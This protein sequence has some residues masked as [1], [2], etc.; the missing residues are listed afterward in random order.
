MAFIITGTSSGGRVADSWDGNSANAPKLTIQFSTGG[1]MQTNPNIT[2]ELHH[3]STLFATLNNPTFNSG[4]G[5]LSWSGTLSSN[6]T[7]PAGEEVSLDITTN[8]QNVEFQIEYDSQTKPSKILLP[9]NTVINISG[10][11]FYDAPY[12]EGT[13]ITSAV[14]GETVYV[15]INVED[16]FGSSDITSTD[17]SIVASNGST[18]DTTLTDSNVTNTSGCS[19][20]YEYSWFTSVEQGLF[21]ISVA[22]HEGYESVTDSLSTTFEVTYTDLGTNCEIAFLDSEGNVVTSYDPNTM[23]CMSITDIDENLDTLSIDNISA[24]LVADSG[25][26]ESMT[27]V[28]SGF[29]TGIFNYCMNSSSSNVGSSNDNEI[30]APVEST[31]TLIVTIQQ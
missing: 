12:P 26:S 24:I 16:P 28:E 14:N 3:G 20:S 15:R 4:T 6:V 11:E 29:N 5:I 2:A 7:L 23:I 22:A 30:Y 17:L 13:Q 9:T 18:I 8:E 27:L 1:S 31:L 19:K 21:T 10:I 25:D